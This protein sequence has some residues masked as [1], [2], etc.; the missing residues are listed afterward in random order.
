M[1]RPETAAVL[2]EVAAERARQ[3]AN[4][5]EQNHRDGTG[6]GLMRTIAHARRQTTEWHSSIGQLTWHDILREEVAEADAET[7]PARLRTELIQVAAVACAWIEAIDRR[8]GVT[9]ADA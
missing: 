3:D 7:D 2:A 5:G 4:W 8:T 9:G 1:P 6:G